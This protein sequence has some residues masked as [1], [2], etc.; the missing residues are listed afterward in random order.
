MVPGSVAINHTSVIRNATAPGMSAI[1]HDLQIRRLV[2]ILATGTR[3]PRK[4][5]KATMAGGPRAELGGQTK[6]ASH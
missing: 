4:Q 1:N 3:V 5:K 2:L 6:A